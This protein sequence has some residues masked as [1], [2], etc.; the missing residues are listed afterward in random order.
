ME[1][2][3]VIAGPSVVYIQ[4]KNP[5]GEL[6]LGLESCVFVGILLLPRRS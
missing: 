4:Q 6:G 3:R 5:N 1:A 2:K